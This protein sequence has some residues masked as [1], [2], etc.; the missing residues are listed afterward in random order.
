[1]RDAARRRKDA[2]GRKRPERKLDASGK[3]KLSRCKSG[4]KFRDM[5]KAQADEMKRG[6]NSKSK[7]K[8][9]RSPVRTRDETEAPT[10]S[11]SPSSPGLKDREPKGGTSVRTKSSSFHSDFTKRADRKAAVDKGEDG[12]KVGDKKSRFIKG[13][14]ASRNSNDTVDTSE[15]SSWSG[16][17]DSNSDIEAISISTEEGSEHQ[18]DS[19]DNRQ[20]GPTRKS[21][22][23][24]GGNEN[25]WRS[26]AVKTKVEDFR[27]GTAS[28]PAAPIRTSKQPKASWTRKDGPKRVAGNRY[29]FKATNTNDVPPAFRAMS[30]N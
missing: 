15:S 22:P 7:D 23:R 30:K 12:T 4:T 2:E 27:D 29:R 5:R 8:A 24:A 13:T 26:C 28:L 11:E 18:E 17:F 21:S 14:G 19:A 6:E 16:S 1:M 25:E 9:P 3:R 20:A 10:S